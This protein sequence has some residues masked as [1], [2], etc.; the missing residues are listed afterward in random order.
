MAILT[1]GAF[2]ERLRVLTSTADDKVL[3]D[4]LIPK[5]DIRDIEVICAKSSA[6]A[7]ISAEDLAAVEVFVAECVIGAL[8][9][10]MYLKPSASPTDLARVIDN[11][12]KAKEI[13]ACEATQN[14][15]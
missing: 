13:R 8:A 3:E 15:L 10:L 7:T 5:L 9:V 1:V 12:L 2:L 11:Q 14:K 4:V 6:G